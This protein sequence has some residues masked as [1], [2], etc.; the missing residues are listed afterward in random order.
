[1]D[2][3]FLIAEYCLA[4]IALLVIAT[5]WSQFPVLVSSSS[6]SLSLVTSCCLIVCFLIFCLSWISLSSVLGLLFCLACAIPVCWCFDPACFWPCLWIK[7]CKWIRMLLLF[8]PSHTVNVQ[9]SL[10]DW[11]ALEQGTEPPTAPR[12]TQHKW[13]PTAPGVCSRCVFTAVCVHFEWVNCRAQIL[14]MGHH[15]WP[16]VTS[17]SLFYFYW[18][19]T[20]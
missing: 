14:S 2:L 8:T 16:Y 12:A 10:H 1:M 3:L 20:H 15:T 13:M 18:A 7:L 11:G 17:L 19:R 9:H 4:F 5:L 6:Y